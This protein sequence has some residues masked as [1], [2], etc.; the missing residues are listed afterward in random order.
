MSKNKEK[1]K[2]KN[3]DSKKVEK[4]NTDLTNVKKIIK[5]IEKHPKRTAAIGSALSVIVTAVF[6]MGTYIYYKGYF[7]QLNIPSAYIVV[8]YWD[9]LYL[10]LLNLAI[11]FIVFV[12]SN[13]FVTYTRYL[14]DKKIIIGCIVLQLGLISAGMLFVLCYMW[15]Y[16]LSFYT[17]NEIIAYIKEAPWHISSYMIGISLLVY[18][19]VWI[20]GTMTYTFLN[21]SDSENVIK[22]QEKESVN[23]DES[24]TQ[25]GFLKHPY[26]FL[27]G[28][29]IFATIL[30]GISVYSSGKDRV[31][32]M[33]K[34]NV[35]T[36]DENTYFVAEQNPDG[37][38]LKEC[39]RSGDGVIINNDH[40]MVSSL[41]NRD[42]SVIK[43]DTGVKSYLVDAKEYSQ[44][45]LDRMN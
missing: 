18:F 29:I 41:S 15:L 6:R 28:V 7:D 39:I 30:C 44:M 33:K 21:V 37:C 22:E 40:Y 4:I 27:V 1:N 36:I 35:V 11:V 20:C 16:L 25:K 17:H 5:W 13:V 24:Q 43:L 12:F 34:I 2:D 3:I 31:N 26:V 32:L 8:N 14:F 42:V 23:A 45:L 9:T 19:T 10:F 38:I